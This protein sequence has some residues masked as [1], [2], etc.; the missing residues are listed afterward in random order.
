MFQFY[1]GFTLSLT[2]SKICDDINSGSE[3]N[4]TSADNAKQTTE[5]W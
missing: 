3:I 4:S 5:E 1:S 2:Y